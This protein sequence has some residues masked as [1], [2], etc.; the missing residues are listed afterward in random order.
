MAAVAVLAA[1]AAACAETSSKPRPLV[2][3]EDVRLIRAP[4]GAEYD[5]PV[6]VPALRRLVV[7]FSPAGRTDDAA[8]NSLYVITLDG[9][10][11]HRL[12]LP[13]RAGCR[14]TSS[15]VPTLLPGGA[16]GYLQTCWGSD[17][18]GHAVRPERYD[19]RT[20]RVTRLRPYDLKFSMTFFSVSRGLGVINDGN[21]LH[22]RLWWLGP[23]HLAPTPETFARAGYPSWSPDGHRLALDA[24]PEDA[25]E[26]EAPLEAARDL[27]LLG[28][29]GR[30]AATLVRAAHDVGP[31]AW[32]P[33]GRWL[34]LA[35]RPADGPYGLY[36]V[37]A[38]TRARRFV[39]ERARLGGVTW[40]SPRRLAVAVGV[41]SHVT[42]EGGPAGLLLVLL[43]FRG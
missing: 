24:V 37:N 12:D 15:D 26:G 33:D 39:V 20:R 8:F 5:T 34:A 7:K 11:A 21:S 23:H 28:R 6:W 9:R 30:I 16:V 13:K 22:E 27:Y 25:A 10:D 41:F 29:D 1:T 17:D 31:A 14:F 38:H 40:I 42:G 19:P 18:A 43:P 36:L 4:A 3:R 32:S 35:M 2:G